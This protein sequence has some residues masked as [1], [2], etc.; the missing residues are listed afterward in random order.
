MAHKDAGQN[1]PLYLGSPA[2]EGFTVIQTV[3]R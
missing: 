3:G 1:T 2:F